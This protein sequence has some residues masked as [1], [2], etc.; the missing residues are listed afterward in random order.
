MDRLSALAA[1][2]VRLKVD[3]ILTGG[4]TATQAAK[5][6]THTI[7]IVMASADVPIQNGFIA[8]LRTR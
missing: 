2:L 8:S 5:Q 7:H 6:A 3:V 1:E 4:S